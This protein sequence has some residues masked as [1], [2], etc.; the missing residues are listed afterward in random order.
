MRFLV[1]EMFGAQVAWLL[2]DAGHDGVH[3][4]E[5]GLLS[6]SDDDVLAWAVA[7]DRVVVT[8]NARD[9]V[10]LLDE[11]SVAGHPLTPVVFALKRSLPRSNRDAMHRALAERLMRWAEEYPVPHR[12][13]HWLPRYR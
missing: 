3:V 10:P 4:S 11:R 5:V 2:T 7:D 12:H 8:E 9:F 6:S 13:V 1:D